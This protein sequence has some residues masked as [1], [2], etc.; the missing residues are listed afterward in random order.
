MMNQAVKIKPGAKLLFTGDSVTDCDRLRPVGTGSRQALG[1][2]YVAEVDAL[3]EPMFGKRPIRIINMGVSGNTVRDLASR[4]DRDVLALEPDWLSVLIGINDV[5]RQFDGIDLSAAVRLDKFW[6]TYDGL[7][8]RTRP[9]LKGLVLMTPYY[10]QSERRDLMR[11]QMDEYGRVVRDLARRHEALLV[12]TQEAMDNVLE[13][14][15]YKVIAPDRV[16]PT[17]VGHKVLAHAF[18]R[19]VGVVRPRS[20]R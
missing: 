13:R 5:W 17:E 6:D 19:A 2:G 3:L 16:H 8:K 11:L 7:L 10:V 4:W 1:Q 20:L 15:E 14:L 9:L 12:D 18:L